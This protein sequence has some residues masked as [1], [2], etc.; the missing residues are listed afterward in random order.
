[1]SDAY[2]T[3]TATISSNFGGR[4]EELCGTLNQFEWA[5]SYEDWELSCDGDYIVYGSIFGR[6]IQYPTS[7]PSYRYAIDAL[8]NENL[9][10]RI[11]APSI[12]EIEI[13]IS[14]GFEMLT[15]SCELEFIAQKIAPTIRDGW[16]EIVS[17]STSKDGSADME[18]LHIDSKF[19]A[20]YTFVSTG[21]QNKKSQIKTIE[22]E[23]AET[24]ISK[25]MSEGK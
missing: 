25:F 16:I 12:Q 22:Y 11:Y 17:Y 8:D 13:A 20:N 15:T 6:E 7:Y 24:Y 1:M 4:L 19:K 21:D 18:I 23:P 2:G 5:N 10:K 9:H 3:I 14:E